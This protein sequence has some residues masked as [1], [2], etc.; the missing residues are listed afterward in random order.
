MVM[1]PDRQRWNSKYG[2]KR[3]PS[4]PSPVVQACHRLAPGRRALD[5]ACGNGRNAVYLAR[6]GFQVL[7]VDIA[8]QILL[9]CPRL[10]GLQLVCADLERFVIP[11]A[12]FHL[13][14]NIRYLN[15]GL[16]AMLQAGLAPGGVLIFETYLQGAPGARDGRFRPEHLL[17]PGE[18]RRAFPRLEIIGYRERPSRDP[19]AP[20]RTATL[21]AR[22]PA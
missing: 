17:Q 14:L 8:D 21:V 18:L 7:G 2:V 22:R 10:P 19:A 6:R 9:R 12:F 16:F 1:H 13:I 4:T 3:F 11:P 5:L 20:S 15:R